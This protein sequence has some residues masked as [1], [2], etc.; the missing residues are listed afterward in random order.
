MKLQPNQAISVAL[1][2]SSAQPKIKAPTRGKPIKMAGSSAAPQS[3]SLKRLSNPE[4]AVMKRLAQ[5]LSKSMKIR[6]KETF[7]KFVI[8][9][10]TG[11]IM[12]KIIN[13]ETNEVIVE[14]PPE[15]LLNMAA[16]MQEMAKGAIFDKKR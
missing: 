3:E 9:K 10:A 7:V 12:V 16:E 14:M 2:K 6:P 15:K 11:T 4:T 13:A 5:E 1:P 8:H